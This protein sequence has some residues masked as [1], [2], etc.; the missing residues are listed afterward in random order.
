MTRESG[1]CIFLLICTVLLAP[2]AT[3]A[4]SSCPKGQYQA[5]PPGTPGPGRCVPVPRNLQG[6]ALPVPHR[7]THWGAIA[8]DEAS[9]HFGTA[10]D[11]PS[12]QAATEGALAQ[13]G[14]DGGTHCVV[15]TAYGNGCGALIAGD[16]AWQASA[17]VTV[18]HAKQTGIATCKKNGNQECR[19]VYSDCSPG[20]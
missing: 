12:K 9:G 17:D 19:V 15:M 14:R 10:H 18:D 16:K 7:A 13:C 6:L 20:K 2:T 4:R 1:L 8:V 3:S 5:L 11:L